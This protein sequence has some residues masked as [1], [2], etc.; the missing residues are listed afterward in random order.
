METEMNGMPASVQGI[1]SRS[2]FL[3]LLFLACATTSPQA[4][5][6]HGSGTLKSFHDDVLN[7]TYFYP[8]EFVPAPPASTPALAGTSKCMQP[9]LFAYSVTPIENSSFALSTIDN[10]CPEILRDASQLGPFT[11]EQ[12]VRQLKQYGDP[13]IIQPPTNYT[14]AGH[15]AAITV[16]S[17]A[18]PASPGKVAPTIYAAK[19]CV[20]GS[21]LLRT[22]KKSAPVEPVTHVLCFDFT[23]QNSGMLTRM[24]SFII[25]FENS[26]LE[27]MFPGSVIRHPGETSRR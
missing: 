22:R 21:V 3:V 16:A 13:A 6:E 2:A 5:G 9:T 14:I 1:A 25:E 7:I 8:T 23:T 18:T 26:P 24:F 10:T 20:V 17:V 4:T 27:P 11:R 19:A 12:I 15:P